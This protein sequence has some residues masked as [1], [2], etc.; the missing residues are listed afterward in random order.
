M[1]VGWRV[2]LLCG[3]SRLSRITRSMEATSV[4][5]GQTMQSNIEN[6]QPFV[7]CHAQRSTLDLLWLKLLAE[8][9]NK[10]MVGSNVQ[11]IKTYDSV[12]CRNGSMALS[13]AATLFAGVRRRGSSK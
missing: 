7:R 5:R 13:K 9:S 10:L 6:S 12:I 1:V 2:E 8:M 11:E 3:I 4:F